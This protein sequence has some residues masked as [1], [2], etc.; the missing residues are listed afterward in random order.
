MTKNNLLD[1][2]MIQKALNDKLITQQ[3]A[4]HMLTVYLHTPSSSSV[5]MKYPSMEPRSSGHKQYK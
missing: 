4:H 1:K 2:S 5:Q 3:E